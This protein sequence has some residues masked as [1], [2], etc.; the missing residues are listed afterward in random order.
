MCVCV[1]INAHNIFTCIFFL[2]NSTNLCVIQW[3]GMLMVFTGEYE[4]LKNRIKN[5]FHIKGHFIVS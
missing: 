4:A 1:C 5:A 2:R 3:C